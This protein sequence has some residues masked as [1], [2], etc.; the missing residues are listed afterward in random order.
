MPQFFP[1]TKLTDPFPFFPECFPEYFRREFTWSQGTIISRPALV[2]LIILIKEGR[3]KGRISVH[4][5]PSAGRGRHTSAKIGIGG[6]A[7]AEAVLGMSTGR[8]GGGRQGLIH[9]HR[10]AGWHQS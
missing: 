2:I 6:C 7:I 1:A 9:E 8:R 3:R 4:R 5:L 10:V